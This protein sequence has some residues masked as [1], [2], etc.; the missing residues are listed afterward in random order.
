MIFDLNYLTLAIFA[1]LLVLIGI[2]GFVL[3]TRKSPTSGVAP[4]I[5][6]IF[7]ELSA[8]ALR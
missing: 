8:S 5:F 6:S 3:P 4:T 2:L 7:A 1:P